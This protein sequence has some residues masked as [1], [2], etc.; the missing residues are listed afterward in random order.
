MRQPPSPSTCKQGVKVAAAAAAAF[1]LL[2]KKSNSW[3]PCFSLC[4]LS[5]FGGTTANAN[6]QAG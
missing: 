1:A 2:E 3:H 4:P 5:S 6:P